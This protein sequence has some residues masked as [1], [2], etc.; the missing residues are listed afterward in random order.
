MAEFALTRTVTAVLEMITVA[1]SQD[2]LVYFRLT[3]LIGEYSSGSQITR[4]SVGED[5]ALGPLLT[6]TS[7]FS[8]QRV[9]VLTGIDLATL[10]QI[11]RLASSSNAVLIGSYTGR[12]TPKIQKRLGDLGQL[13]KLPQPTTSSAR[14]AMFIELAQL[15]GI[16]ITPNTAKVLTTRLADDWARAISVIS[17]LS[18]AMIYNPTHNQVMALLGRANASPAPWNVLELVYAGDIRA[19]LNLADSLDPVPLSIWVGKET[20]TILRIS[21]SSW[22]RATAARELALAP[23]RVA[24]LARPVKFLRGSGELAHTRRL[25]LLERSAALILA[26]KSNQARPATISA[27]AAWARAAIG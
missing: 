26:A 2:A 5:L 12:L 1:G 16:K 15:D 4:V 22:D 6:E 20:L 14:A 25:T 18:M 19:A 7:L 8:P 10:D 11:E 3:R 13:I 27:L 9:I 23:F 17:Q 21:E 24:N